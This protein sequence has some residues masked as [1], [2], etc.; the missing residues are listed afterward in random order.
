MLL[1]LAERQTDGR[2]EREGK[3]IAPSR[4]NSGRSLKIEATWVA[5]GEAQLVKYLT[6]LQDFDWQYLTACS[7]VFTVYHKPF[8]LTCSEN[9]NV[10]MVEFKERKWLRFWT[11]CE[12][13]VLG[14]PASLSALGLLLLLLLLS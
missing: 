13:Q 6:L 10:K 5:Q 7:S 3:H 12:V 11:I 4:V 2:T 9:K 14:G 8:C 1:I